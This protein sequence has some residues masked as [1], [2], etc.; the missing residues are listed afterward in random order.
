MPEI[1]KLYA[2]KKKE[3]DHLTTT[4]KSY[5]DKINKGKVKL[6]LFE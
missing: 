4:L 2:D 3:C 5:L 1:E 6:K